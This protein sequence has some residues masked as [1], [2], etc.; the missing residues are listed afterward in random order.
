MSFA[1][2]VCQGLQSCLEPLV[3]EPRVIMHQLAPSKQP[4]SSSSSSSSQSQMLQ[5]QDELLLLHS[6]KNG[7]EEIYVHPLV[8]RSSSLLSTRSL[9]MC[10]ESLGS[11]TGSSVI[12][13]EA[14][15]ELCC[16]DKQKPKGGGGGESCKKVKKESKFPPPLSSI[17]ASEG[18]VQVQTHRE[19]GRLVIKA[20][21]FPMSSTSCFQAERKNGRLRLSLV[22]DD[23]SDELL[24]C[25]ENNDGGE[26]SVD[27]AEEVEVVVDDDDDDDGFW[28]GKK[29]K[30]IGGCKVGRGGGKEWGR[31]SRSRW[32]NG[33]DS[34]GSSSGKR[35]PS[36]PFCVAI[37]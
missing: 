22:K 37:S 36:L 6:D 19:G 1:S 26:G 10:T 8:R 27:D 20:Y 7:E 30:K 12:D 2:S 13:S 25:C 23:D 11:E 3:L 15:N 34:S 32:C 31:R 14:M 33:D 29:K 18:G 24:D 21:S 28:E 17:S 16:N 35:V 9:E 4:L 5:K